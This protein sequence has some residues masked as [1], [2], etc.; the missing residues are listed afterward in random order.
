MSSSGWNDVI[1]RGERLLWQD[2]P[3][4]DIRHTDFLNGRLL[5][6]LAFTAFAVFWITAAAAMTRASGAFDF[7][8][9]FGV[10]FVLVGLH[11]M[12]GAPLWDAY[13]RS[14][15]WYALSDRAAYIAT[16]LIGQRKLVRYALSEMNSIE[17]EDGERGTVWFRRDISVQSS[18]R[19]S[20]T[21]GSTRSTYFATTRIGFKRIISP[22]SVH[23]LILRSLN[24][25][26]T[27]A[28]SADQRGD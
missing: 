1:P 12:I 22:R 8:P 6:G 23:S 19:G 14:R 25:E 16:E 27:N 3:A 10:P 11:L 21:G 4:S 15:S 7:F 2:R 20:R 5:F 9:L 13:E 28:S 18:Y 26:Q 24:A 17:L